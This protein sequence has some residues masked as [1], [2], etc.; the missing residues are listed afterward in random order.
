MAS[1]D[2]IKGMRLILGQYKILV[3]LSLPPRSQIQKLQGGMCEE[4]FFAKYVGDLVRPH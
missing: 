2:D 1:T 4:F 3:V